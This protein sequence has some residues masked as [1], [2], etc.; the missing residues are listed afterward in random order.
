MTHLVRKPFVRHP[1]ARRLVLSGRISSIMS[2]ASSI[3]A[4]FT[5]HASESSPL[6][7]TFVSRPRRR[8]YSLRALCFNGCHHCIN[9]CHFSIFCFNE[10]HFWFLMDI[11]SRVIP[12]NDVNLDGRIAF[13]R[14]IVKFTMSHHPKPS[15]A[16][17]RARFPINPLTHFL[18]I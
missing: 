16:N 10:N 8:H 18:P 4:L 11:I 14:P 2:T 12:Q 6:I 17:Q 7:V 15:A 5:V 9:A 3:K 13:K 1:H